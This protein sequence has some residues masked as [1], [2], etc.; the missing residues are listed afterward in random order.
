MKNIILGLVALSSIS[1]FSQGKSC[2]YY[3]ELEIN[4]I[5]KFPS[6]VYTKGIEHLMTEKGYTRSELAEEGLTLKVESLAY[7]GEVNSMSG[8]PRYNGNAFGVA[9]LVENE[10]NLELGNSSYSGEPANDYYV[11]YSQKVFE[12]TMQAVADM[13]KC[14]I[15]AD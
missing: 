1:A 15:D 5:S 4:G 13:P 12:Y 6:E 11:D 14:P 7:Q 10:N 2:Q 8:A 3:L 9:I